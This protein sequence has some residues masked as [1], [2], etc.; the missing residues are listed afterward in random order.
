MKRSVKKLTPETLSKHLVEKQLAY[1]GK[2]FDEI[3][4]D[5][6]WYSNNTMTQ[7]QYNEWKEYCIEEI[8]KT[9]NFTKQQANIEFEWFSLGYSL[10]I[11]D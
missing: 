9:Y 8:K 1:I 7:K 10:S 4:D 3:K 6:E 2:T 5:P 11:K